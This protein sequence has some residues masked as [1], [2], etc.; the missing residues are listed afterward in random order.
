MVADSALYSENNLKLMGDIKWISRVPL[1]IKKAKNLVK[2]LT[3]IE[4]K[5]TAQKGYSYYEQQVTYGGIE[6]RWVIVE[7]QER[8]NADLKKLSKEIEKESIKIQKTIA[9]LLKNEFSELSEVK[10]KI[11]EIDSKLKYHEIADLEIIKCQSI[12]NIFVYKVKCKLMKNQKVITERQR[13]AGRFIL[14]TNILDTK[15][16]NASE[17]LKV[18][19]EQQSC[20]SA[21]CR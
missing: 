1:S 15:E 9:K 19:K 13:Q 17:V 3:S 14:A 11:S 7:S 2:A 21:A 4:F 16:L 18:Y 5:E 6:Q 8:K 10:S 20:V 12:N